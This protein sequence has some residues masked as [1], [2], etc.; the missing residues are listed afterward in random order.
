MSTSWTLTA[1]E[2][3]TD[4][5]QHLGVLGV[6]ET[7]GSEDMQVALRALDGV[8]KELPLVGY[9]WPKLSAEASLSW[10]GAGVQTV[11]LPA[12]YFGYPVVW[13]TLDGQKVPL[14]PIP[15]A[16]WVQMPDRSAAGAVTHFYISPA[17]VL[18][19]WPVP[20]TDDPVLTIQYQKIVDDAAATT[21]PDLPQFWKNPLGYGVAD[22]MSLK[23]DVAPPKRVEIAQ[24]WAAKRDRALEFSIPSAP[25]SFEVQ[26]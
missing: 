21:T 15:H 6:G 17:N 19:L 4:A 2:V 3:C 7:P 24:R 20:P 8:L 10:G 9:T 23:F 25:I 26:E 13:K 14:T 5:L 18:Y 16:S 11:S 1:Q 22:E 12:D